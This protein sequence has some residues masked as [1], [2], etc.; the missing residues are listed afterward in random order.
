[1][2]PRLP[3][4]RNGPA[5]SPDALRRVRDV[6]E[7]TPLPAEGRQGDPPEWPAYIDGEPSLAEIAMWDRLWHLPQALIWE[8]D[9]AHDLVALY[10]RAYVRASHPNAAVTALTVVRQYADTLLLSVPAL[11]AARYVIGNSAGLASAARTVDPDRP[12]L[13]PEPQPGGRSRFK[14]VRDEDAS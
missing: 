12:A 7:W 2:A 13:D 1:M 8:A 6:K 4:A 5:P 10:V 9:H 3:P 11:H 14:I